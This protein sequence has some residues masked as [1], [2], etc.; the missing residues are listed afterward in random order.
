MACINGVQWLT[1]PGS[2]KSPRAATNRLIWS[3]L[4]SRAAEIRGETGSPN[5]QPVRTE[6]SAHTGNLMTPA[7]TRDF[8]KSGLCKIRRG[9]TPETRAGSSSRSQGGLV[10]EFNR[11]GDLQPHE[12]LRE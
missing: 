1:P 5:P 2:V 6:T 12:Q 7:Y 10:A 9:A 8:A 4:P 3:T 11:S